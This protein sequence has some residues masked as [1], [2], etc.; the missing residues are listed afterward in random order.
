LK[1]SLT[2]KALKKG[3]FKVKI[4]NLRDFTKDKHRIVDD[5]PFGGG[6]GMVMKIEPIFK[7]VSKLKKPRNQKLFFLPLEARNLIS[8]WLILG[9]N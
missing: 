6:S 1:E 4:H 2:Q 5:R 7:A 9:A 8:K 3:L